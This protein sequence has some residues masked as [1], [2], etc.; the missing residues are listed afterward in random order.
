MAEWG[1]LAPNTNPLRDKPEGYQ[2]V[3][4]DPDTGRA[5]PFVRNVE[6][7][8]ASRQ[9]ARLEGIE[10]PIDVKFGPDGA[11][12]VVD[13]GI[14]NVNTARIEQGQVPYEFPPET[15]AVWRVTPAG[16]EE[17]AATI[18]EPLVAPTVVGGPTTPAAEANGEIEVPLLDEAGEEVGTATFAEAGEGRVAVVVAAEGIPEGE[19]G[20][21]V[22][23]VGVCD[24]SGPKPFATAGGHFN[25]TGTQHGGPDDPN[26]HAGDL[27][28]IAA[29][30]DLEAT[31]DRFTLAEGAFSLRDGDG[32]ALLI[33]ENEDDL[34]TDP[35]GNSGGRIACG[36]IAAPVGTPVP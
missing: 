16:G 19:H 22:H 18:E 3:R 1:D 11:M 29:V 7:G 14:A 26:A 24:P 4:I 35:A 32:S 25:P 27:G 9:G 8:P 31:T 5:E 12:Y 36:V 30:E 6:A 10:R 23:D 20:I 13:Y 2:V 17:D 28:N 33:H 15:G 34:E 21:H